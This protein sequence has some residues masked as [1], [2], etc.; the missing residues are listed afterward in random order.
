MTEMTN[1]RKTEIRGRVVYDGQCRMCISLARR[2][3][4]LI[5]RRGFVPEPF[6]AGS[7]EGAMRLDLADGRQ[8]AGADA[9]LHLAR[10]VWWACPV[11][12]L[13]CL[14]GMKP[15]LRAV[16]GFIAR[17]RHCFGTCSTRDGGRDCRVTSQDGHEA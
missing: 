15:A 9:L 1:T 16:Y 8:L 10:H 2:F 6:P 12:V 17:N 5:S 3:G 4:G 14:P 13:G 7:T 11:H